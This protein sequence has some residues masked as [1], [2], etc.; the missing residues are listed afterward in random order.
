MTLATLTAPRGSRKTG[1]KSRPAVVSEEASLVWVSGQEG[2]YAVSDLGHVVSYCQPEKCPWPR[3]LLCGDHGRGHRTVALH[4]NGRQK[5]YLIHRLVLEAFVGP[6][7][8]GM[9]ARHLNGDPSDNRVVNLEWGT[10]KQNMADR[11]VHGT[12]LQGSK[13]PWSSMSEEQ[14]QEARYQYWK[15]G[16]SVPDIAAARGLNVQA[17]YGVFQRKT[18]KYLPFVEGEQK[19][20]RRQSLAGVRRARIRALRSQ[21]VSVAETALREGC[22]QGT[23]YRALKY[24]V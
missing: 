15:A 8:E 10:R 6:R 3:L 14:V 22:S 9:E 18:W 4:K 20:S 2:R 11:V 21:G 24:S 12:L 17:L 7:L 1:P 23:V 19:G 16:R 5:S 13:A